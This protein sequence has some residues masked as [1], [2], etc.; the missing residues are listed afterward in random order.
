MQPSLTFD[1]LIQG[2]LMQIEPLVGTHDQNAVDF[3]ALVLMLSNQA[4]KLATAARED[5]TPGAY[6][7]DQ[8]VLVQVRGQ[9]KVGEDYCQRVVQKARPWAVVAVLLEELNEKALA[10]GQLGIDLD[11]TVA[12]AA[13]LDKKLEKTAQDRADAIAA[14]LKEETVSLCRGKTTFDGSID[15]TPTH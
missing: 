4:G 2:V 3:A 10:A 14:S 5:L 15:I 1:G 6:A 9:V 7:V 11:Q 13:A 12:R 8:T